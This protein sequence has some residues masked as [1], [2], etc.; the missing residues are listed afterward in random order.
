VAFER[1]TLT[2]LVDRVE[3]DFVS[4]LGLDGAALLRRA[5]V[6][7]LARVIAG[8]VHMLYGSLAYLVRQLFADTSDEAFLTRDAS[9]LGMSPLP[10]TYATGSV[11]VQGI[12]GALVDRGARL[13]SRAGVEYE[14][15]AAVTVGVGGTAMAPISAALAGSGGN[16][17]GGTALT[18]ES[19]ATGVSSNA[20]VYAAAPGSDAESLE[21]FRSRY[22]ARRRSP[23]QGGAEAD[24]IAWARDVAGV[25]RVWVSPFQLGAGTVVVRFVRDNDPDP[26]PSLP[27]VAAVQARINQ[28]K[29]VTAAVTV[30]APIPKLWNFRLTLTPD[31]SA[32]RAAV[33][34]SVGDLFTS[35]GRPGGIITL[36]RV[37]TAIGAA[38]GVTDY[39]LVEP[40]ADLTH[41]TGELPRVGTWVWL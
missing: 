26:I 21:A 12:A 35:A 11:L 1:P 34:K 25:T 18:W 22:L 41:M 16:L 30:L 3:Q 24:Y 6:R 4:R 10:A 38:A 31:T 39:T 33:Q 29:P 17:V 7:V 9:V 19:P 28:S 36:S 14:T 5:V 40:N 8:A 27:A 20:T 15:T 32:T 13:R 2:E 23:P 37:R